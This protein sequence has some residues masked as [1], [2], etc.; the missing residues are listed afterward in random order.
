[1]M[2]GSLKDPLVQKYRDVDG[3]SMAHKSKLASLNGR[4][5][6]GVWRWGWKKVGSAASF[7]E[8]GLGQGH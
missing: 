2:Q 6:K 8:L 5:P 4:N 3:L 1:M 7:R